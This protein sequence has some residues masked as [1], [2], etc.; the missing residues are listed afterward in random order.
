[1]VRSRSGAAGVQVFRRQ[2]PGQVQV[3]PGAFAL[4]PA[5]PSWD[6]GC[7][8]SRSPDARPPV[9][10]SATGDCPLRGTG[11]IEEMVARHAKQARALQ[12]KA[13]ERLAQLDP[14]ELRPL[15]LLAFVVQACKLER[16]ALG[17]PTVSVESRSQ[18]TGDVAVISPT[19]KL[20]LPLI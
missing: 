11:L 4:L 16:L 15:E 3:L 20:M 17:E 5:P 7:R 1:M 6:L 12:F 8:P 18:V 14:M 9:H 2:Q 19:T 10:R 13:I